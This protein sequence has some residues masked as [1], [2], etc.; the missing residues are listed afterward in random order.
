FTAMNARQAEAG[1]KVFANPRNAAA[2]SLRQLDSTITAARPLR[3]FAYAWGELSEPLAET[4]WAA[5]ERFRAFGFAVCPEARRV[6]DI[7]AAITHYREIEAVRA[8][9][10]Y[11]IDGVVYKLD[12]LDWQRRMG[13]RSNQPRWAIAHKFPAE[14]AQT[15]LEGIDIQVGRT[16][17][18][19]PTARL[20]PVT[21]GGVV[22]S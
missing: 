6:D 1:Q 9:L 13:F 22:V 8:S 20:R 18:L 5:L 16:G 3:F 12:R 11:D 21:V 17:A 15:V 4:Q 10:G 2:G 19:T 14:R 7:A